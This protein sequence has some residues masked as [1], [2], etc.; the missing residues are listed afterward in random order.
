LHSIVERF[1]ETQMKI[2]R[3]A[4]LIGVVIANT[5]GLLAQT[6]SWAD[7]LALS[8]KAESDSLYLG[9]EEDSTVKRFN[10][11]TGAFQGVFVTASSGGLHGP[12]GLVFAPH[13]DLLVVNQNEN[14][15]YAGDVLDYDG[16]SGMF[17]RAL[18]SQTSS[19]A[20]FAPRG[21][22]R[23]GNEIVVADMGDVDYVI[24][25]G[26]A[27]NPLP[28]RVARY[29]AAS[30]E[31]LGTLNYSGFAESCTP[32]G[33]C[34]QWSPRG[35]VLGPDD[36]L[37]VSAMEFMTDTN[38]NTISGRVIRF[39]HH[40]SDQGTVFVEGDTCGC[41]LARPDGLVFGPDGQLYVTSFRKSAADND[42]ILVF[43]A[44]GSFADKIDLDQV[45]SPPPAIT[46]PRAF[47]QAILFGP[48]GKLFVPISGNGPDTGSVRRYEVSTKTFDVFISS[49]ANRG[50][51]IAPWYLTFGQTD[52]A[53]LSYG[54]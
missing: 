49:N 20:P 4:V 12:R 37:Y 40:G 17:Q 50:A 51:A 6:V 24:N 16:Q 23:R 41:D 22:L 54:K 21:I 34:V 28:A 30:G 45:P 48:G 27:P 53:T 26:L 13:R 39:G 44:D 33:K 46:P 32:D 10:A 52:S 43:N 35:I 7:A 38:P 1:K 2:C 29:D 3:T 31:F 9:D 18:V 47:A 8:A 5:G 11:S 15:P 19:K 36:A 14:Q 42:K 25:E